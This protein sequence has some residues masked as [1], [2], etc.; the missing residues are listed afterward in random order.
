M[1]FNSLKEKTACFINEYSNVIP[2]VFLSIAVVCFSYSMISRANAEEE[3]N[4][5]GNMH[6]ILDK[7]SVTATAEPGWHVNV[8]YPWSIQVVNGSKYTMNLFF[9]RVVANNLPQGEAIIKGGICNE[10][11]CKILKRNVN[12][13]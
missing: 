5:G 8:N 3:V 11:T 9:D 7:G 4:N 10:N 1:N 12:I 13:P 2:V 6:I